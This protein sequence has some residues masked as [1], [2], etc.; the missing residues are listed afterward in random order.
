MHCLLL[1][2]IISTKEYATAAAW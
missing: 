1:N 2:V